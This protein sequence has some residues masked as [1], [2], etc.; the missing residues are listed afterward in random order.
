MALIPRVHKLRT[1]NTMGIDGG[2]T[3]PQSTVRLDRHRDSHAFTFAFYYG[4]FLFSRSMRT[5][6]LQNTPRRQ[7][8]LADK[9]TPRWSLLTIAILVLH[10]L[11]QPALGYGMINSFTCLS[12]YLHKV[13][14][15]VPITAQ[16]WMNDG[17]SLLPN[18]LV[19]SPL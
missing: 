2:I 8:A 7:G 16:W 12:H 10:T 11:T 15:D 5:T 4:F 13:R 3:H 9:G 19:F 18:F 6:R 14:L 1:Q 17:I